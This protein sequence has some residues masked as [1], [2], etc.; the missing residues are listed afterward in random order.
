MSRKNQYDAHCLKPLTNTASQSN[1]THQQTRQL[2]DALLYARL[3]TVTPEIG[4]QALSDELKQHT[5]GQLIAR[6]L[7]DND[8]QALD[9]AAQ[10]LAPNTPNYW[11]S[12][13]RS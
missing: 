12:L 2:I 13:M 7:F 6:A 11:V 9:Q 8:L 3:N 1:L 4:Y 10:L 5:I